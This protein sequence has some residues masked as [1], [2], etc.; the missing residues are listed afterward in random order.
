LPGATLDLAALS[1]ASSTDYTTGITPYSVA[2]GDFNGDGQPDLA[3]ANSDVVGGN[4]VSVLL[5][6][7]TGGFGAKTDYGTGAHPNSVAVGDF[8]NDGA[9]DLAVANW[10]ADSVSVLLGDDTGGFA[11]KTDYATGPY[12]VSVAVGDFNGDGTPDLVT[13]DR[14]GGASMLLGDGSGGF[15]ATR[16]F[17]MGDDPF[18]IAVGDFNRDG[19]PDLVTTNYG[20]DT[21]SVVLNTTPR[22]A[23]ARTASADGLW[24]FHVGAVDGLDGLGPVA[25]CTVRIDTHR[26]TTRAFRSSVYPGRIAHLHCAVSDPRP[27]AGWARVQIDVR[28][29]SGRLVRR[30]VRTHQRLG[31]FTVGFR[32][33]LAPGTYRFRVSATDAAGNRQSKVG[34]SLLIVP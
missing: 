10:D 16:D 31:R 9:Q 18:A 19:K 17:L 30:V 29:A 5:G 25:T 32:C 27:C 22:A 13:A 23:F 4:T 21:V 11:A 34:S 33:T 8:N 6:D 3:V 2:V 20:A 26:P 7:G 1:L 14:V 28:S 12:P 24:Y 15:A